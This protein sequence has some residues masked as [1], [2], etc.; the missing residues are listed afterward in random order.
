MLFFLYHIVLFSMFVIFEPETLIP[1]LKKV[2]K[3]Y[4]IILL[5]CDCTILWKVC[6]TKSDWATKILFYSN[7]L[8]PKFTIFSNFS[9]QNWLRHQALKVARDGE[10]GGGCR[11]PRK[12]L[13]N[14]GLV[15]SKWHIY[16]LDWTLQDQY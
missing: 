13:Q 16:W 6:M 14:G 1:G 8:Q 12:F 2:R 9:N 11:K 7:H 10:G 4:I 3:N 5:F 15:F